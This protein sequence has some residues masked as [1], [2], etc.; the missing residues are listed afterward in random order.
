[1]PEPS[2]ANVGRRLSQTAGLMPDATALVVQ[3]W[4]GGRARYTRRTFRQL[5]D[6]SERIARGLTRMGIPPGARLALLVRPG[7]DFIALV[8][9]LFKAG[10]VQ[11]LIDPGMGR[12]NAIRCLAET[13]PEG[14]I[15]IPSAHLV[16]RLFARRFPR[17]RWNVVVGG[18]GVLAGGTSSGRTLNDVRQL[19]ATPAELPRVSADDP[20]A[21]IFTTGSTGPPK[22]VLYRHGNFDQQ[23]DQ[24]RQRYAIEPG[25]IDLACFP[26]FA[27]FNCA[28][29]V[30]TVVPDMDASRPARAAPA[31]L[32]AAVHDWGVTQS[33]ASPA[34]WD[35]LG[36]Y[37]QE[38]SVRLPTLRRVFSAGAPVQAPVLA[39]IVDCIA[40]GGQAHTPYGATEALPVASIEAAEVLGETAART[41]DGGGVCV[42]RRFSGIEWR[43][44]RIV[45][46]PIATLADSCELPPGEIGEL[47][48]R[49]PVVTREYVTRREANASGKIIDGAAVWHRMGDAGYLDAQ[50]RFWFCGRVAH[51][52]TTPR[53]TLFTVP[54]EAIFNAHPSIRRSALVGIGPPGAARPVIVLEPVPAA[55]SRRRARQAELIAAARALGAAHH[56]TGD[57]HDFLVHRA[58]PVDIRHNAKIFR[59]KLAQ[60]AARRLGTQAG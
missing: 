2:E 42:G 4:R 28:M 35:R 19:G 36:R 16:R 33:F 14:F 54:C 7:L 32:A 8:F 47:I 38:R 57:I 15:A 18:P 23:V 55:W 20:A 59:E 43:V 24:I 60:W 27:L 26:L 5:D 50:D 49:G 31:R 48:V 25:G 6:D 12:R 10:L 46:G 44:V 41:A 39:R 3:R 45:D 56:L 34:V 58:F 51:R 53:G 52:V 13:D 40:P 21:I 11:V 22:G 17:A 30:T 9:A 37:C 1:M 29:G